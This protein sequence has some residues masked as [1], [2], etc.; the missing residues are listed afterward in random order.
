MER[1]RRVFVAGGSGAI[2]RRLVPLL[3]DNGHEVVVLC[4]SR[5]RAGPL[6]ALGAEVAVADALD[7][8]ALLRSVENARPDAIVHQLTAIPE[9]AN[10]RKLDRDFELTN[11]LRTD[12]TDTLLEAARRVGA[13]RFVAQS[14]CGWTYARSGSAVKTEDDPL[15]PDPPSAFRETLSAIRHVEEAVRETADVEGLAL[16]YGFFYGP[17]TGIAHDGELVDLV[18]KRRLPIVGDG[19][20]VWSFIHI[21]DAAIATVAALG[22]GDPGLYNVVDDEPAPVSDWLPYLAEAVDARPPFRIPVWLGRLA[23]GGGGVAMMTENRGAANEKT[24]RELGW[25][26]AVPSWR[27]GF[28]KGLA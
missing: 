10:L 15:E 9:D 2:G 22:R 21:D 27:I 12:A 19:G 3:L 16:R 18:R 25:E 23:I 6:E 4:R 26:P 5:G 1:L 24:K 8:I 14:F 20:G 7:H 28:R 11:R 13:R 17:G